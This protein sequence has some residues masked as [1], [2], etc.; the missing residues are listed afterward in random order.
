MNTN[1]D[2]YGPPMGFDTWEEYYE[3]F[4]EE[5]EE[6]NSELFEIWDA[7]A[8]YDDEDE[9]EQWWDVELYRD[10]EEEIAEPEHYSLDTQ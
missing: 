10:D 1:I 5:R 4:D 6:D 2:E 7:E 9:E 3:A 8:Y